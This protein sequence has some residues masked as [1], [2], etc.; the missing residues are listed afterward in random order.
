MIPA[1]HNAKVGAVGAGENRTAKLE[2]GLPG[3][4]QPCGAPPGFEQPKCITNRPD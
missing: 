2:R 1:I 4:E 3:K